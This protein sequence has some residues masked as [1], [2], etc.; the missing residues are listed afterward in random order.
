MFRGCFITGA[1]PPARPLRRRVSRP[2]PTG[3]RR[4][5]GRSRNTCAVAVLPAM[6]VARTSNW[7][8]KLVIRA[9]LPKVGAVGALLYYPDGTIQ[10]AG[11][12]LGLS[13]VAGHPFLKL[14]MGSQGYIGRAG[15]EQDLSCVTAACMAIRRQ[16]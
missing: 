6:C 10:H 7:L 3:G 16:A 8:Q 13:G 1:L 11:V 12:I 9:E 15:L 4:G 2:S 14:S 5:L